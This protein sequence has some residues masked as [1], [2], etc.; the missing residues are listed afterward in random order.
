MIPFLRNTIRRG[1]V[2]KVR[3]IYESARKIA[4]FFPELCFLWTKVGVFG[5]ETGGF[6]LDSGLPLP[7]GVPSKL[8]KGLCD[9]EKCRRN[10]RQGFATPKNVI[11]TFDKALRPRKTSSKLSTGLCDPEKRRRN[12]RRHKKG[13]NKKTAHAEAWTVLTHCH[14]FYGLIIFVHRVEIDDILTVRH[15]PVELVFS[16]DN[17]LVE[18]PLACTGRNQM[19]TD[20]IFL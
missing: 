10:L 1:I 20:D 18:L 3:T 19:A 5:D 8:S 6:F 12:F 2:A 14:Y 4:E 11:E 9:P 16:A 13:D 15:N 7:I 17:Q